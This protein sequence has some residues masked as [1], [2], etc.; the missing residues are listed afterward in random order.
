MRAAT[1]SVV[2]DDPDGDRRLCPTTLLVRLAALWLDSTAVLCQRPHEAFLAATADVQV[3]GDGLHTV[4]VRQQTALLV[5]MTR[6]LRRLGTLRSLHISAVSSNAC[7][8]AAVTRK[9]ADGHIA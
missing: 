6:L 5:T 2:V 3:L 9:R 8:L 4:C 1:R 7:M